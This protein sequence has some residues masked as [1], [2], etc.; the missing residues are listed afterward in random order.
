M[1]LQVDEYTDISSILSRMV[2]GFRIHGQFAH[3][4]THTILNNIGQMFSDKSKFNVTNTIPSSLLLKL[5]FSSYKTLRWERNDIRCYEIIDG[6]EDCGVKY[7]V[8]IEGGGIMAKLYD[9]LDYYQLLC[10]AIFT[11]RI[12]YTVRVAFTIS[13]CK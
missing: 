4:Q 1:K 2:T 6:I 12:T 3:M 5:L 7:N 11:S 10:M 8:Q 9:E 13:E